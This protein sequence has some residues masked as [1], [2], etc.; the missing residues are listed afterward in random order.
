MNPVNV[1]FQTSPLEKKPAV[2]FQPHASHVSFD[3]I[4][5]S[6]KT[7]NKHK[8]TFPTRGKTVTTTVG[9]TAAAGAATILTG[10]ATLPFIALGLAG[11]TASMAVYDGF[12]QKKHTLRRNF[13]IF[14]R[15][16]YILEKFRPEIQQ[17]FILKD[18][19]ALPFTHEQRVK[20]TQMSKQDAYK[21]GFGSIHDMSKQGH[22]IM[23]HSMYPLNGEK[24]EEPRIN[25]G[26]SQ[27]KQ[28]YN[29]SVFNI[30]A[31]SYG[32]LSAEAVSAMNRGARLG[33]FAQNTGE[34]GISEFHLKPIGIENDYVNE[35]LGFVKKLWHKATKHNPNEKVEF[36]NA[37]IG[38][39]LIWQVGTGYFGARTEDGLLDFDKFEAESK[40]PNV[41][42]IELKL[43]QG[44]KPGLGGILPAS[45]NTELIAKAR[46]IEPG[47]EV[48]SPESHGMF[49]TPKGLL[50]LLKEMKARS[51]GKP[52]GF[53]LCVGQRHEFIALCKAMVEIAD[54]IYWPDFITVDG[55]E[56]GTGAAP[57]EFSNNVGL[58]LRDGLLFVNNTLRGFNLKDEIKV[59]ASGKIADG[60]DIYEKLA[61]GADAV[62]SARAM[63]IATGCIMARE[64]HNNTCP[65]GVATQDPKLRAGLDVDDKAQR[66][67]NYHKTVTHTLKDLLAASG[68][69]N[70]EQITPDMVEYQVVSENNLIGQSTPLDEAVE[71]IPVGS[72]L[73]EET[74]PESFKKAW[75]KADPESPFPKTAQD[76]SMSPL[77]ITPDITTTEVPVQLSARRKKA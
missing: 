18:L 68:L 14:A 40:R 20:I 35:Q 21:Q 1:N 34:G 26:N 4:T 36:P 51:G 73:K 60:F 67:Y 7:K 16:R 63:M 25:L 75:V 47:T 11:S 9:A 54:P 8:A 29:M 2:S 42:A 31:M 38:G 24:L 66:V 49:D 72:L 41:K 57:I 28:P 59:I 53:K 61:L 23:P 30:S 58:P 5:F 64:C 56:G 50:T 33:N 74:V 45:K 65:T 77:S 43:S 46:G 48:H 55:G 37:Q 10:G 3:C 69:E 39:D 71:F 27:C 44:A 17:Y 62:N 52:V 22:I 76:K 32:S 70:T 6:G 19:D 15:F 12:I 13:P